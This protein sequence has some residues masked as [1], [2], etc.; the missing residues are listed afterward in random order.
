MSGALSPGGRS[1]LTQL[2]DPARLAATR[3]AICHRAVGAVTALD[4][5]DV[6]P[7]DLSLA[8]QVVLVDALPFIAATSSPEGLVLHSHP[9]DAA[10]PN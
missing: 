6:L 3:R 7:G 1:A 8:M 9:D 4:P 10:Q 5:L 2:T